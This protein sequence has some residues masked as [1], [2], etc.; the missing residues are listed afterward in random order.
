VEAGAK[1]T[2]S[3]N[4][5][6]A[7]AKRTPSPNFLEAGA[8]RTPSP[9]FLAGSEDDR[10]QKF[11]RSLSEVW[12]ISLLVETLRTTQRSTTIIAIDY[13]K[14]YANDNTIVM[15]KLHKQ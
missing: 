3:P 12:A 6:E 11:G 10:S 5:L 1:R 8:K 4:F 7:G 13:A 15:Q 9:N 2:P 14:S